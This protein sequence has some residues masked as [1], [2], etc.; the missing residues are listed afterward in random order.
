MYQ[1]AAIQQVITANE[2]AA[3]GTAEYRLSTDVVLVKAWD[4]S[5][6]LIDLGGES[7][8]L[9]AVGTTLLESTLADGP[10]AAAGRVARQYVVPADRVQADLDSFL[11]ELDRRGLV[12]RR[13][14]ATRGRERLRA[15]LTRPVV[16][17]LRWSLRAICPE[18]GKAG[19]L[20]AFA[21]VC[22]RLFGWA[23]TVRLWQAAYKH[24]PAGSHRTADPG[25]LE[26]IDLTVREA[27]SR[28][29]FPVDC[30]ARALCCWA[31]LRSA[32]LPAR[33]VVGVDLFPFL[34]HCWCE[35]G[36]RILA[37]RTDRCGRFTPVLHYS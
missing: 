17:V 36:S 23:G 16:G 10:G 27:L 33:L 6:R 2:A 22:L 13:G 37:D 21:S 1:R 32:G 19:L 29:L 25:R 11:H 35:S 24:R 4:G 7:F 14:S 20:L 8:G 9:S 30:K 26:S 34:G 18:S 3:G 15:A 5:S 12:A 31:L 28:S